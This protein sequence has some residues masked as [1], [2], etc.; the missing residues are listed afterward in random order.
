MVCNGAIVSMKSLKTILSIA[1]VLICWGFDLSAQEK[2]DD[3]KW[4]I[5]SYFGGGGQGEESGMGNLFEV[6]CVG[7]GLEY[8]LTPRISLEGEI[9]YLPNIAH[10]SVP[11]PGRRITEDDKYRL[12]WDINFLFYFGHTESKK[13]TYIKLFLT[14]GMGYQYDCE[15]Y[16]LVCLTTL[17][18]YKYEYGQF[19]FQFPTF[20]AGLK[21]KIKGD[22]TLRLLYKIHRFAGEE[23]QTNRLALGLSYRL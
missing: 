20:G 11:L 13:S 23:L 2:K 6:P 22:W 14:V 10:V 19:W 9:N 12:L 1:I 21:M 18:Q 7:L 17:E 5:S 16:I 8:F 4:E 3:K 15:E